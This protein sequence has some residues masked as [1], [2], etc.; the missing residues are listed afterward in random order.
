MRVRNLF[1]KAWFETFL[2]ND[3]CDIVFLYVQNKQWLHFREFQSIGFAMYIINNNL[4]FNCV[5]PPPLS[6]FSSFPPFLPYPLFPL[7]PFIMNTMITTA[8]PVHTMKNCFL[9]KIKKG[10][11]Q[12]Y[13]LT[14]NSM[15]IFLLKTIPFWVGMAWLP[16]Q[17]FATSVVWLFTRA[18]LSMQI[19]TLNSLS[20]Y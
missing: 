8:W 9:V 18:I 14:Y 7:S 6:P 4:L 10:N 3:Q 13:S 12:L 15:V 19:F 2:L 5:P 16:F 20:F 1:G 11:R 17:K